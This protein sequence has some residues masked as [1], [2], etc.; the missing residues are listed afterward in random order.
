MRCSLMRY[1]LLVAGLSLVA[2]SGDFDCPGDSVSD[3]GL[4]CVCPR[5]ALGDRQE[6]ARDGAGELLLRNDEPFC[7][8]LC[9]RVGGEEQ[10]PLFDLEAND[11]SYLR[12][13][14]GRPRCEM[15]CEPMESALQTP[16]ES[17]TGRYGWQCVDL[18]P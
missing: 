6:L 14:T 9:E 18:A 3:E 8:P 4:G 1:G 17:E 13:E 7:R 10:L 12:D 5:D 16:E 2:C 11:G 15:G